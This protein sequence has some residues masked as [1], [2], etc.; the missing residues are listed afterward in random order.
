MTDDR[1]IRMVKQHTA[2][3]GYPPTQVEI[4]R[5]TGMSPSTVRRRLLAL[6]AAGHIDMPAGKRRALRV[7]GGKGKSWPM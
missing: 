7:P 4:A 2:R 5:A 3:H 6:R 1:I